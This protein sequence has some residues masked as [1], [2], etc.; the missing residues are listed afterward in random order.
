VKTD[1]V[2][3]TKLMLRFRFSVRLV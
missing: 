2:N 3:V 1:R